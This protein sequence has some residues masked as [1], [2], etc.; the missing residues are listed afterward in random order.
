M[1]HTSFDREE[2]FSNADLRESE[3][4]NVK[5][6]RAVYVLQRHEVVNPCEPKEEGWGWREVFLA[7]R[8]SRKRAEYK[9]ELNEMMLVLSI[10][11]PCRVGAGREEKGRMEARFGV[12]WVLSL[13]DK[14]WMRSRIN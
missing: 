13:E 3:H 2:N 4:V 10:L 11:P 6:C 14:G 5:S 9:S 12:A 1:T 8:S 7:G